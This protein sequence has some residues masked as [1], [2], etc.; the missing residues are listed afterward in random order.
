MIP[1]AAPAA[2]IGGTSG[3]EKNRVRASEWTFVYCLQHASG[4]PGKEAGQL[5]KH[6]SCSHGSC[7]VCHLPLSLSVARS[8]SRSRSRPGMLR[9]LACCVCVVVAAAVAVAVWYAAL[10]RMPECCVCVPACC[11]WRRQKQERLSL[12]LSL[13]RLSVCLSVC[14]SLYLLA[15]LGGRS[16]SASIRHAVV[17]N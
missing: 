13:S 5:L 1:A 12:S 10:P 4:P 3:C 9:I 7:S 8:L 15:L 2:A 14:L 17:V 16:S 6:G 11:A